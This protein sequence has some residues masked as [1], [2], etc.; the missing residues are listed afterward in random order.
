MDYSWE[1]NKI[2]LPFACFGCYE[3]KEIGGHLKI[4]NS[5]S[6][7]DL[8]QSD[9]AIQSSLMSIWFRMYTDGHSL[10]MIDFVDWLSSK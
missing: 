2:K 3:K 9:Q 1:R 10:I 7:E 8:E 4:S 6:F 5:W